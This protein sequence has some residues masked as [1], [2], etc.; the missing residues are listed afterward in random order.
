MI[1]P[2]CTALIEALQHSLPGPVVYVSNDVNHGVGL[3]RLL[4]GYSIAC[5]DETDV[6]H[7]L[8]DAGVRVF[9]LEQAMGRKN[10]LF[11]STEQLL[12]HPLTQAFLDSLGQPQLAF[13]K[14]SHQIEQLCRRKGWHVL[15]PPP[16]LA[17]QMEHKLHFRQVLDRLGL[18]GPPGEE[19]ELAPERA[20][21]LVQRHGLP[22]VIQLPRGFGGNHTFLVRDR[23]SLHA[24]L[25]RHAGRPGRVSRYIP[26]ETLTI[27]ACVT[28]WG[29]VSST[30]FYQLTGMAECTVYPLGACGNDWG[31]ARLEARV[32]EQVYDATERIGRYLS[33]QGYRG[34]FGLDFVVGRDDRRVYVVECNPRLV[35]S[36]PLYTKLQLAQGQ[37]PLLLL[38]LAELAGVPY[39]LDV[40][41][42]AQELRRPLDGAQAILHNLSGQPARVRADVRCGV[43]VW[44]DT[45]LHFV[46]EGYAVDACRRPGEF[47]VLAADADRIVNPAVECA[48]VQFPC[49]VVDTGGRLPPEYTQLL[50]AVYAALD[51]QP[52][53]NA[54]HC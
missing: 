20:E 4:P 54:G 41:A 46:R 11:R 15:G 6:V 21:E 49:S 12:A 7:Y 44:D 13:F 48:R 14:M 30:P 36:I 37:L 25:A 3:E 16:L 51:L 27:N 38:H 23:L 35:A 43:Y 29:T 18:P 2:E 50:R 22:L 42:L 19:L 31:T 45:G 47:L 32:L 9:C 10:A 33:E 17:R 53:S 39:S 28:R 24:T 52:E 26:G 8:Q 34:I 5:I 1:S 40:A